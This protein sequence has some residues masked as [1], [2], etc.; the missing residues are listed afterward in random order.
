MGGVKLPS[1]TVSQGI[2]P[3]NRYLLEYFIERYWIQAVSDYDLYSRVKWMVVSCL[4]ISAL[5]GDFVQTAQL[6]SKEIENSADNMDALL[7]AMQQNAE[8]NDR[9]LLGMA[10]SGCSREEK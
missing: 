6:Y 7:D 3:E 10:L 2:P 5:G 1:G 8:F 9:S 4:V